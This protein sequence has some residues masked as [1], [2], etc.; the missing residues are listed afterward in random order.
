MEYIDSANIHNSAYYGGKYELC[1]AYYLVALS[2]LLE[3]VG[4]AFIRIT[5]K[6]GGRGEIGHVLH[7]VMLWM[8]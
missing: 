7:K 6:G 1:T 2:S 4:F 8:K 3:E 5:G